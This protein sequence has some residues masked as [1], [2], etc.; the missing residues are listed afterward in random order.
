VRR[1]P[2]HLI[3]AQRQP[4]GFAHAVFRHQSTQRCAPAAT[5]VKHA[6]GISGPGAMDVI[7]NLAKLRGF[8][9]V[10]GVRWFPKCAGIAEGIVEPKAVKVAADVVMTLNGFR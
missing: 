6:R 10:V 3:H 1:D 9:I 2:F 8:E 4:Y 5:Y 7:V